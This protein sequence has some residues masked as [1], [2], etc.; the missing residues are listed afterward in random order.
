MCDPLHGRTHQRVARSELRERAREG[1]AQ[2][3][4]E[5]EEAVGREA[6]GA[7]GLRA[8]GGDGGERDAVHLRSRFARVYVL[9]NI[10]V[11]PMD[12]SIDPPSKHVYSDRLLDGVPH[13]RT[14]VGALHLLEQPV[15]LP[16]APIIVPAVAP[17]GRHADGAA[18]RDSSPA[19]CWCVGGAWIEPFDV[20]LASDDGWGCS[21]CHTDSQSTYRSGVESSFEEDDAEGRKALAGSTRSSTT[22]AESSSMPR[23]RRW[24]DDN[25][26]NDDGDMAEAEEKRG[27]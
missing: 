23:P 19:V 1:D 4:R 27:A 16:L 21:R 8:W 11:L 17:L 7:V 9:R 12:Q 10:Y 14:R 2:Q 26:D 5:E 20:D 24:G 22:S 3:R 6:E 25:D 18:R 13:G 15:Q